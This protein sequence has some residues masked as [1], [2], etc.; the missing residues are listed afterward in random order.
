[1][2]NN[3]LLLVPLFCLTL[4]AQ[5][6]VPDSPKPFQLGVVHQ[7]WSAELNEIRTL[8]VY[9]PDEYFSIH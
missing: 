8:N 4:Q 7:F 5:Q 2:K 3:L 6:P 1:M 9:L